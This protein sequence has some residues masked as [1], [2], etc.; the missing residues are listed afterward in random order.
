[1]SEKS[2]KSEFLQ[3]A[4]Y[5]AAYIF[6][7]LFRAV[8]FR[9][10]YIISGFLGN[11]LYLVLKRRRGV[12]IE[13]IGRAFAG[14]ISGKEVKRLARESCKSLVLTAFEVMKSESLFRAP[15][16]KVR[17]NNTGDNV[18]ELFR[19]AKA[20]HDESG[21]C[22][23]VTPHIGNWE[24]LPAVSGVVG[25]PLVIVARPL[26]NK[27]LERLFYDKRSES[28][29]LIIPK[30]NAMFVLQRTLHQG[31]SIGM[32]TDQ[33]TARGLPVDFFGRKALTT[34]VPAVLAITKNR[35]IVVVACCRTADFKFEGF[36]S[37]P[38]RPREHDNEKE[39]LLR[40]TR[41]MNLEME[42]IIRK[43]PEQYLWMHNR[44]KTYPGA[45]E[46][47]T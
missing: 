32:L 24:I 38:I 34:P 29:Q 20:L 46:V 37:D 33:S 39:E 10:T 25:I 47:M 35:P 23:F 15:D 44:W 2:G 9:V 12:A 13:N 40:L 45:K 8:P 36:V 11:I 3:I 28:G 41:A 7:T 42:K 1:M 21:G 4:E 43:Y 27:Y 30:K 18:E 22:I 19:K 6:I 5:I 17:I 26:D 31:R 14:R 16:V